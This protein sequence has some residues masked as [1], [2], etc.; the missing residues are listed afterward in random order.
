MIGIDGNIEESFLNIKIFGD[1]AMEQPSDYVH[2]DDK[3][4]HATASPIADI[5]SLETVVNLLIQKGVCT[6]EEL[7]EEERRSREYRRKF[8]DITIVK[9][10]SAE[11]VNLERE[12]LRRK[13]SWLKR[14]M[15]KRRWSR[16]LGTKLFGWQWKKV[17]IEPHA[18]KSNYS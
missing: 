16:Q 4:V 18:K 2:H 3:P 5:V 1:G 6:A 14:K 8:K 9:S 13:Q 11:P 7:F 12:A 15:S 17:K 10:A